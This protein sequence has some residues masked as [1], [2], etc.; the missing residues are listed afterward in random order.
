MTEDKHIF[1]KNIYYMLSYAFTTLRESVYEDV[2]KET[3]DS[4]YNLFAAILS[5]GIGL[6]LKQGLYREYINCVEDLAVVR[7]KVDMAGTIRNRLARRVQVTCDFDELSQNN[8]FNQILKSVVLLLLKQK[9][10]SPQYKVA[11]KREMLFFADIDEVDLKQVRWTGIRFQRNNR[12]YQLLLS[13]CQLI[14]EGMLM[15]TEDGEYRLASFI[16]E[17][18]MHRLYEKFILEY[19]AQEFAQHVKGFSAR[20][21]QIPWDLDD[22]YVGLLPDMQ[23]DI[24]LSYGDQILIIDAKYYQHTL[25][26]NFGAHKV[27]SGNLYQIYT[28]VK[29]KE[30]QVK[31]ADRKVSGMLLYARTNELLAPDD[32]YHISGN[33]ISVQTLDLNK[34]FSYISAQLD[35]IV[36]D[37]FGIEKSRTGPGLCKS[38]SGTGH[39]DVSIQASHCSQYKI[40]K[41]IF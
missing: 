26:E 7:G 8:L 2:Q 5:K 13:I 11:L 30:A 23:T 10:V 1:I 17:Q 37:Q 20:A 6:Q 27:H 9:D 14:V 41:E 3:F 22:G 36:K 15:T 35:R 32:V 29:N 18:K 16:D 25:Q 12:T 4:I 40:F 31:G 38:Y 34:E 19:Y 28:Y 39:V 24:T 33:K 21:S